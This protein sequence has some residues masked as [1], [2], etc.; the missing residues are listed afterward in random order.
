MNFKIFFGVIM[1][2]FIGVLLVVFYMTKQN[3]PVFL[4]EHGKPVNS[5]AAHH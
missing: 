5:A 2:F 4:D 3:P 1:A